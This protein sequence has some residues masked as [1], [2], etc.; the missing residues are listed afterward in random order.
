MVSDLMEFSA[1]SQI[2]GNPFCGYDNA[3]ASANVGLVTTP[4]CNADWN[5]IS[6]AT[7]CALV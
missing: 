2:I 1:C 5:A 7:Y 6:L 3:A 4:I